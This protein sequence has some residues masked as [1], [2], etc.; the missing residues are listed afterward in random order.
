MKK[1]TLVFISIII[2]NIGFTQDNQ[3]ISNQVIKLSAPLQQL[4]DNEVSFNLASAIA[5]LPELNYERFVSDNA[6][7]GFAL[8]VSLEKPVNMYTRSEFMPYGR[9][10]FGERK[11]SGFYNEANMALI[12]Q[13]KIDDELVYN[14]TPPTLVSV[15][16]KA[17]CFG[18]GGAVG[19]KLQTRNGF[20]G[21]I[22][23]GGGR[24]F[25]NAL[26][27]GYLRMGFSVGKRF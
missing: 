7:I 24:A 1:L 26:V 2:A 13:R 14:A 12:G 11:A 19:A 16:K 3:G 18:M 15:D 8:A 4:G 25:G 21:E 10:Y 22:Y 5:G 27:D 9:I 20:V 23:L 6:G 17:V